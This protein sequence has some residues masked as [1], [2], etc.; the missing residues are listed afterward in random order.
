[1]VRSPH[2]ISARFRVRLPVPPLALE[3]YSNGCRDL[4]FNQ[5]EK[6]Q[7]GFKSHRLHQDERRLPC[8]RTE[9]RLT[10]DELLAR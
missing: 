3:L 4:T 5:R 9:R 1:V 8:T 7:C 10:H 6:S 2:L